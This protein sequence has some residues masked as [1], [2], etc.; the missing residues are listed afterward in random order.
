MGQ[1]WGQWRYCS[2]REHFRLRELA[3]QERRRSNGR[4]ARDG[5]GVWKEHASLPAPKAQQYCPAPRTLLGESSS[6]WILVQ[7]FLCSFH[8]LPKRVQK[9]REE[10]VGASLFALDLLRLQLH[11]LKV[12]HHG[13]ALQCLRLSRIQEVALVY[14]RKQCL[15]FFL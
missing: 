12:G 11:K 9:R 14:K 4:N 10:R 2:I 3:E 7:N 1:N 8:G 13:F 15:L 6:K 5:V